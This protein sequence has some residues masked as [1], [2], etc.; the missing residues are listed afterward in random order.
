MPA[1]TT[2]DEILARLHQLPAIPAVVQEV[3]ASFRNPD[4]DSAALARKI[5][6]DQGLSAKVLR[7]ANSTFYGLPRKVGS[8]QDAVTVIGIN[9]VRSL[10]LSAGFVHAFPPAAHGLF[11]RTA[12]WKRSFRVAGYAKALAQCLRQDQQTAFTAGMFYD[13]GELVLDICIPEQ[14]AGMLE[15]QKAAGLDLIGI[16]QSELGCDHA[17]I[18]A[19]MARRWN[20]PPE[21]EHAI[22]Y[23]RTP[24]HEPFEPVTGMVHAAALLESGLRGEELMARLPAMLRGHLKI[25]WERI[26]ACLPEPDQL[27]AG[28]NLMLAT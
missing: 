6:Q 23:W 8:V 10:A 19:E 11:D 3:I 22:R 1:V 5:A 14:F 18:G 17:L 21:I 24:E 15:R 26:E 25:S 27:D 9:S 4:L 20:F 2:K 28:A 16:E 7:V 12:F 13:I